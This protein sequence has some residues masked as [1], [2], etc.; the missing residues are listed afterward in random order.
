[1]CSVHH[2]KNGEKISKRK[3]C[4]IDEWKKEED[5]TVME[6]AYH[7]GQSSSCYFRSTAKLITFMTV[8]IYHTDLIETVL[9]V[10]VTSKDI[11]CLRSKML[12]PFTVFPKT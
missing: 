6:C 3:L 12:Y 5:Q 7:I 2:Q 4:F 1:M 11:F 9:I 10:K 8:I